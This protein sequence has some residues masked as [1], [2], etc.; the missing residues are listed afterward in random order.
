MAQSS[1]SG[2]TD[3]STTTPESGSAFE[4]DLLQQQRLM[5][6]DLRA[7]RE[8]Q[9]RNNSMAANAIRGTAIFL[10]VFFGGAAALLTANALTK[11]KAIPAPVDVPGL[12]K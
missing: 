3:Q 8:Q 1:A 12:K 11:P 4:R 10:A 6:H 9:A 2:F 5:A 7:I